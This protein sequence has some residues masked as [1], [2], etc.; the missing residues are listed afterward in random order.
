IEETLTIS[1]VQEVLAKQ[2][3][4]SRSNRESALKRVRGE[5]Q[6]RRCKETGHNARTCKVEIDSTSNSDRSKK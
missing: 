6:C 3:G 2:A 5:R 4:S 1:K